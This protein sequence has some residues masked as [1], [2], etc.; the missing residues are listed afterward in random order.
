LRK[1]RRLPVVDDDSLAGLISD[2]DLSRPGARS[3]Q[4]PCSHLLEALSAATPLA[5]DYA[6][7]HG[8]NRGIRRCWSF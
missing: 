2:G 3:A 4:P 7:I 1:E 6:Q 8:C 5:A